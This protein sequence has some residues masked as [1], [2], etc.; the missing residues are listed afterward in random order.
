MAAENIFIEHERWSE[1]MHPMEDL[2][3]LQ[4]RG[5]SELIRN[6][7]TAKAIN[8]SS[9]RQI[10][11]AQVHKCTSALRH[12]KIKQIFKEKAKRLRSKPIQGDGCLEA[13]AKS[14]S[15]S[16]TLSEDEEEVEQYLNFDVLG[17]LPTMKSL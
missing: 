11:I 2:Q 7:F 9:V 4:L 16:N 1:Q 3:R 12:Y 15:K 14:S 5:S 13:E 10:S 8:A 6:Y 17:V